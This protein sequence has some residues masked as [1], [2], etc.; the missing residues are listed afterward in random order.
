MRRIAGGGLI[1]A[2]LAWFGAQS[3]CC[4]EPVQIAPHKIVLNANGQADDIQA[5]ISMP[6]PAGYALGDFEV[7][8][9]LDGRHVVNAQTFR[10]CPIDQNF[11]AGFDRE[12]VLES[13]VVADLANQTVEARVVGW[14]VAVNDEGEDMI[15]EFE[16]ADTVEIVAPVGKKNR[17]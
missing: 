12:T 2:A 7:Q 9:L 4:G 3:P 10:Y 8:L 17:R 11:L 5:I 15:V 13:P 16:G 14:Y 6:L 1:L